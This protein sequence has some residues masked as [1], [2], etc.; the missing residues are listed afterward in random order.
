MRHALDRLYAGALALAAFLFAAIGVLVLIQILGRLID[1]IAGAIGA[2]PLGFAIPSL[3]EIGGFLFLSAVFL[4]LAGTLAVG[5]HVRVTLMTRALPA[6]TARAL[7]TLV[8]AAA[9]GLA[10]FAAW[11]S[12]VQM[13]DSWAFGAV[14]YGTVQVPL[15]LPQ[16]AMTLGL[17]LLC[18]A[19]V[20]ACVTLA[21]G[22]TPAFDRAE[23]EAGGH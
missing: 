2:A 1:R 21:R 12:G 23:A 19:L 15:W 3:A 20:D 9:A 6:G 17:A 16:G 11:T 22:G 13:V 10:A 4:G 7:S 14:S 18:L 8:A 5:G